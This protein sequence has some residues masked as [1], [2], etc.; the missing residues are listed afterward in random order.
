M[1]DCRKLFRR[2]I[3]I[4]LFFWQKDNNM[5]NEKKIPFRTS[6]TPDSTFR[7]V[8]VRSC[9]M[10]KIAWAFFMCFLLALSGCRSVRIAG[11]DGAWM[12]P[13]SSESQNQ[14]GLKIRGRRY[15]VSRAT[16]YFWGVTHVNRPEKTFKEIFGYIAH[17]K[18]ELQTEYL[19][20]F[21]ISEKKIKKDIRDASEQDIDWLF[22]ADIESWYQSYVLFFQWAR[23]Q[24]TLSCYS[25]DT[26]EQVWNAKVALRSFYSTDRSVL[27]KS[28]NNIFDA[29]ILEK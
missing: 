20:E 28:L 13:S 29:V 8:R 15:P 3:A 27:I 7:L 5:G 10:N 1:T 6:Q 4:F 9:T 18:A 21:E 26:G 14:A 2:F 11:R 12:K 25:I 22:V 19:N 17:E 16:R 23:I 24:Y